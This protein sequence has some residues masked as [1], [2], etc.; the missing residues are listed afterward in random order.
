MNASTLLVNALAYSVQLAVL[1]LAVTVAMRA[2]W[3]GEARTRL[4]IWQAAFV[5]ALALPVLAHVIPTTVPVSGIGGRL[6]VLAAEAA[7][8]SARVMSWSGIV[9]LALV[10]GAGVRLAVLAAGYVR[11]HQ[12][13][14]RAVPWHGDAPSASGIVVRVS[15]AISGPVTVGVVK[16]VV[17]VPPR[18]GG[19]PEDVRRAVL[20]HEAL[21]AQRRDPL[22]ILLAELWCACLWFHPAARALVARLELAREMALDRQTLDATGNR[23]AYAQA[24]LAFGAAAP[25][26]GTAAFIHRS[27]IS[28]RIA[29]ISQEEP[30]MP[31]V[32]HLVVLA[33]IVLASATA[34]AAAITFAPMPGMSQEPV[35]PGNGVQLPRVIHEVKA[36][37][38]AE[39]LQARIQGS[40]Y[41]DVVV[42][43][44]GSVG[45]V[46]V[47]R[48]LDAV[49]GID[50]AAVAAAE[51]WRFEP[52]RREGKAVAVLIEIEMRFTLK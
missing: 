15:D 26:A 46:R 9:A 37:Y 33:A 39:A 35:R 45:E 3:L 16:P 2:I 4:A 30:P 41:L 52:G 25:A 29:A 49:Y 44:D 48:S 34:T 36:E 28:R 17:L 8:G 38:P 43:A 23:R 1:V 31:H 40:V 32:R 22:Q 24:L 11:I 12:W 7:T 47:N 6:S 42:Q 19:L 50:E 51:Q 18:F 5:L 10:A 20:C 27:H 14:R 13:R 21:H